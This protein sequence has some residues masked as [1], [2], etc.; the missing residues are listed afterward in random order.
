MRPKKTAK[1]IQSDVWAM[2]F[3]LRT[4]SPDNTKYERTIRKYEKLKNKLE[5]TKLEEAKK[6]GE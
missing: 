2:G 4:M 5:R 1:E 6:G 3:L